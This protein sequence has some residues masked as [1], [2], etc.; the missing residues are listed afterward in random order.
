[1][2]NYAYELES[3]AIS[4]TCKFY[5]GTVETSSA[6]GELFWFNVA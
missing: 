4:L 6:M 1:M 3:V 2:G 5:L